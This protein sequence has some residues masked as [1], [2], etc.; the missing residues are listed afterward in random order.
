MESKYTNR[1]IHE[2][3]PYLLQHAHNPVDWYPWGE[4]ALARAKKEDKPILL[5]IGYS[6]CHWCHVMD[7]ESFENEAIAGIMNE[8]FISI[9]VDRE[10]R[11]DLDEI[12]MHAVQVM[13]GSGGW[14]M[15]VFLTP[16]LVPF[17]AGTY[18]PPED[19]R[20]MPGFPKVLVTVSDYYKTHREEIKEME[21]Q[22]KDALHQIVE[23][24]P[25]QETLD[26]KVF[27]KAFGV[28]ESQF[29]PI[30]GG[31]GQ[32]R[33]GAIYEIQILPGAVPKRGHHEK[34]QREK[35]RRSP[36]DDTARR[37]RA[38]LL[39]VKFTEYRSVRAVTDLL[40]HVMSFDELKPNW[41][42]GERDQK[43]YGR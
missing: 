18:F 32:I 13:T 30:Y 33:F 26:S 7:K 5:S 10:E 41:R 3:S 1:L 42:R 43:R 4:E 28:S 35:E 38:R 34:K 25:S 36:N 22:M 20:G 39:F 9:K 37:R 21:I 23:I 11:P 16:D 14:P 15:T 29:D 6:A 2:T 12:Y 24:V 27:L 17:H 40:R 31:F 19:K 8:R